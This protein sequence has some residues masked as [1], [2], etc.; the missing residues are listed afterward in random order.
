MVLVK[1]DEI[2][3]LVVNGWEYCGQYKTVSPVGD[4]VL[5]K[6]STTTPTNAA[7]IIMPSA[8]EKKSTRGEVVSPSSGGTV[9]VSAIAYSTVW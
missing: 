8:I 9:N 2:V 3:V 4:R 7:G 5:V 1:G 6:L